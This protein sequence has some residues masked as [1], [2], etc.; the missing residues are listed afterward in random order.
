MIQSEKER[1]KVLAISVMAAACALKADKLDKE[2]NFAPCG[3]D[4]CQCHVYT[5]L[6]IHALAMMMPVFEKARESAKAAEQG[7]ARTG[8]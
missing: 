4:G 1:A 5:K 2:E 8:E 6:V 3:E 7:A